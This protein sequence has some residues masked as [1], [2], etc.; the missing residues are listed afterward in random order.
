VHEDASV[1]G[2][3]ETESYTQDME[4][5][6]TLVHTYNIQ[7]KKGWNLV[8]TEVVETYRDGDFVRPLKYI[9]ETVTDFPK[10]AKFVFT[11]V[12]QM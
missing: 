10:D 3:C 9:M 7:L 2:V 5:T 11:S 12:E 8:R 6:V 4:Q 1:I